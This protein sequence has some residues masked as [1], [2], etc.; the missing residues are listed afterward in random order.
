M[1]WTEA[2]FRDA[3]L[4]SVERDDRST[5]APKMDLAAV[6]TTEL[7]VVRPRSR[8]RWAL[9]AAALMVA[10][11]GVGAVATGSLLGGARD[12]H[13]ADS[14]RSTP[15]PPSPSSSAAAT[16]PADAGTGAMAPIV[17]E[18][19]PNAAGPWAHDIYPMLSLVVQENGDLFSYIGIDAKGDIELGATDVDAA[20]PLVTSALAESP[21]HTALADRIHVVETTRSA[22]DLYAI[23]RELGED[24]TFQ[25]LSAGMSYIDSESDRLI[26]ALLDAPDD[27]RRMLAERYGAS[28]AIVLASSSAG[29]E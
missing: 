29:L 16:K 3:Y 5:L 10:A 15:P 25:A 19:V 21:T 4:K 24:P 11:I 27:F 28:V 9:P 8:S 20:Q 22:Q 14:A 18:D 12:S 7:R 1:S 17:G 2:E 23:A 6:G 13:T 26:I